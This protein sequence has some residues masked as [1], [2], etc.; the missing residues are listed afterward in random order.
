MELIILILAVAVVCGLLIYHGTKSTEK[1]LEVL[2][3]SET[4][5]TTKTPAPVATKKS[6][7]RKPKAAT[8]SVA[9]PTPGKSR[10]KK[11]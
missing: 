9:K 3:Q 8:N 1:A 2:D 11:V 5:K 7:T 6:T 10:R 4:K